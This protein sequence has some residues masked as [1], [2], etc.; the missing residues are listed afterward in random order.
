MMHPSFPTGSQHGG[1]SLTWPRDAD[2]SFTQRQYKV[3]TSSVKPVVA[4]FALAIASQK[5]SE[6]M[7]QAGRAA[8]LVMSHPFTCERAPAHTNVCRSCSVDVLM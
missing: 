6:G 7:L 5:N 2:G 1:A 4:D 8:R 3:D